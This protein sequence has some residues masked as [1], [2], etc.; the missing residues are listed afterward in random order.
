MRP[1]HPATHAAAAASGP[2]S[3]HSSAA[4]PSPAATPTAPWRR[5][6]GRRRHSR[7][8]H[9]PRHLLR[10]FPREKRRAVSPLVSGANKPR[11]A[12]PLLATPPPQLVPRVEAEP[13]DRHP[14][15]RATA[16]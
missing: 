2:P 3:P 10:G 12:A 11:E 4:A 8:P 14:P 16:R 7:L 13:V 1:R 5:R 15:T 6:K 9:A